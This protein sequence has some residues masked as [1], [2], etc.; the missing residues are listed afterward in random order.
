MQGKEIGRK[1][2]LGCAMHFSKEITNDNLPKKGVTG[3]IMNKK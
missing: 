3:N 2:N 1:Y